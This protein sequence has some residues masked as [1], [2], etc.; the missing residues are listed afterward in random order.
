MLTNGRIINNLPN[1]RKIGPIKIGKLRQPVDT[2]QPLSSVIDVDSMPEPT[3]GN[4]GI[5]I[6]ENNFDI[7]NMFI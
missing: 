4:R 2:R 6:H 1:E 5:L 3:V 7:L